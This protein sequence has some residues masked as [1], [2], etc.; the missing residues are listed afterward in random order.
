[1]IKY[2]KS[3]KEQG[4]KYCS[5]CGGSNQ[6][7]AKFCCNCGEG[8]VLYTKYQG[9]DKNDDTV[10]EELLYRLRNNAQMWL[11]ESII[12]VAVS[13][14]MGSP[15]MLALGMLKLSIGIKISRKT[16]EN[17]GVCEWVTKAKSLRECSIGATMSLVIN[18]LLSLLS[19]AAFVHYWVSIRDK[20]IELETQ[21]RI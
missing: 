16:K 17:N 10:I 12:N 20:I 6:D 11:T 4:M 13:M 5:K 8:L 7:E 19:F 9:E 14:L 21:N 18:P 3:E 1:M 15:Q 2:D